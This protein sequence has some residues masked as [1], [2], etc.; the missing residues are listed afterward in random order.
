MLQYLVNQREPRAFLLTY[1]SAEGLFDKVIMQSTWINEGNVAN[2]K[3]S[4]GFSES[5][6]L[7][8]IK[9]IQSRLG[10]VDSKNLLTEMRNLSLRMCLHSESDL[11]LFL[12][13]GF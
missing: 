6:E 10:E 3:S 7:T 9:A 11:N 5:A 1:F 12:T 8:G 13:D 4:N 2:L